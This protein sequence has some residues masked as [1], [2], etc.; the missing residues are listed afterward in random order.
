[1]I[2]T[3][4]CLG[5]RFL[6]DLSGNQHLFEILQTLPTFKNSENME[7]N[8]CFKKKLPWRPFHFFFRNKGGI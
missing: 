3:V 6:T 5:K 4:S 2:E 7:E 1:M 8:A